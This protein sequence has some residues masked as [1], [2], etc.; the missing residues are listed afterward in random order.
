MDEGH[1]IQHISNGSGYA[2]LSILPLVPSK[3]DDKFKLLLTF[4]REE[5]ML[6]LH[7]IQWQLARTSA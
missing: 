6:T 5:K 1:E 7:S 3:A 2:V 4:T